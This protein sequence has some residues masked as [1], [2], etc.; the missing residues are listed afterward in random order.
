MGYA[1]ASDVNMN[2][3][4]LNSTMLR[5]DANYANASNFSGDTSG[6]TFTRMFNGTM[7]SGDVTAS[8]CLFSPYGNS[9]ATTW[10]APTTI[11]NITKLRIYVDMLVLPVV[12]LLR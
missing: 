9:L 7:G 4:G 5:Q 1:N 2:V 11:T 8:V 12:V 6:L 3:G 10:T